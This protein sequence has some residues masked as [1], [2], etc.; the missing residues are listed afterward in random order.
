MTI[1]YAYDFLLNNIRGTGVGRG[2]EILVGI[3]FGNNNTKKKE[4]VLAD[5]DK[6]G[7]PDVYDLEP[8]TEAGSLV[9]FQGK[10]IRLESESASSK[11]IDT[12]LIIHEFTNSKVQATQSSIFFDTDKY[13]V[14]TGFEDQFVLI[15]NSLKKDPNAKVVISGYA[16][17]RGSVAYNQNLGQRRAQEVAKYLLKNYGIAANRMTVTISKGKKELL[18][19]TNDRINRRVDIVIE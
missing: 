18:S 7:I 1:G 2:S 19:L 4:I 3:T 15:A 6:D 14:K 11:N 9:N 13:Q 16:D 5:A 12:V 8:N 10:T 17:S